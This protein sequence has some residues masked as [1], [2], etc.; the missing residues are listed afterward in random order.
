MVVRLN[1]MLAPD[2]AYL[3]FLRL[4]GSTIAQAL[5]RSR[6]ADA[7]RRISETLQRS[8]LARPPEVPGL[9]IAVRYRAAAEQAQIGGDWYDAFT[10]ADGTTVAV[11][12]DIAGHDQ[13]AAAEMA[14]V[15]SLL[16]GVTLT[17]G[18]RPAAILEALDSAVQELALGTVATLVVGVIAPPA[19]DGSRTLRWSNAGHPP[20]VLVGETGPSRLLTTEPDVLLGLAAADRREHEL[21]LGPGDTLLLY[22]DGLVERRGTSMTVSLAWLTAAVDRAPRADAEHVCDH[23]LDQLGPALDDDVA[24]LA[25]T[26]RPAAAA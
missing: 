7:E 24:I 4:I 19:P 5:E 20:P 6:L 15:R 9:A 25:I 17:T 14:Q 16:R 11:I 13:D 10:L 8:L 26:A 18:A 3:G 12:G 22:T 21:T 2:E 23:L 1:D